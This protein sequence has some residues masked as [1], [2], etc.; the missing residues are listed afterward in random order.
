MFRADV[1]KRCVNAFVDLVTF[2]LFDFYRAKTVFGIDVERPSDALRR[3][4]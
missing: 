4:L 3:M 1:A 2:N